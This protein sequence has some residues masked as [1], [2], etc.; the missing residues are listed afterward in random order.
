M[1]ADPSSCEELQVG[2]DV[3]VLATVDVGDAQ[4]VPVLCRSGSV[5][6]SSFHP[7]LTDDLRLHGL[8]IDLLE[9][10]TAV[11]E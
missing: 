3:E 11:A 7:E 10:R 2:D 8:F 5:L 6:V 4:G 1:P 9:S